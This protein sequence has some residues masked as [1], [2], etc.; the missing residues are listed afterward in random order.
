MLHLFLDYLTLITL[1]IPHHKIVHLQFLSDILFQWQDVLEIAKHCQ[2]LDISSHS[3]TDSDPCKK[4]DEPVEKIEDIE[5]ESESQSEVMA[6][7]EIQQS[8]IDLFAELEQS[9]CDDYKKFLFG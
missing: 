1:H 6:S 3:S 5:E 2:E 7:S 9:L 4:E 8:D